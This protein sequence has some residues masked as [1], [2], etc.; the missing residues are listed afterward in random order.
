VTG[1]VISQTGR[2]QSW[3]CTTINLEKVFVLAWP[4]VSKFPEILSKYGDRIKLNTFG[5]EEWAIFESLD[6]DLKIADVLKEFNIKTAHE[7]VKDLAALHN[8]L[9][10]QT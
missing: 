1:E 7:A 8:K 5:E 4:A 6:K 2:W 3:A 10:D 9:R